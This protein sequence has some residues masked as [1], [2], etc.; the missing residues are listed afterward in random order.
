MSVVCVFVSLY[1]RLCPGSV[2]PVKTMSLHRAKGMDDESPLF[3]GPSQVRCMH[4]TRYEQM[5]RST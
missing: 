5:T 2:F 3:N 4:R 1:V